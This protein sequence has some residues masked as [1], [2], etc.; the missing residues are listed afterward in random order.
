[1]I[2]VLK[3]PFEVKLEESFNIILPEGFKVRLVE[4]Q[5]NIP[6]IW[7][8]VN[9][10]NREVEVIF[11]IFGTGQPIPDVFQFVHSF[12]EPPYVWHLYQYPNPKPPMAR[13]IQEVRAALTQG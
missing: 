1:M 10:E 8:E 5:S 13:T 3:Y 4:M 11:Q 2:Y 7:A 12:Q 6:C 9:K